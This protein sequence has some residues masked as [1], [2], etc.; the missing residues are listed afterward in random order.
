MTKYDVS[1]LIVDD[2]EEV[3]TA[4]RMLLKRHYQTI[5]TETNPERLPELMAT[6]TF[7]V[8]LLDMNFTRDA[9]S[10][11]EGFYWLE[12]IKKLDANTVVILFTA[13]GDMNIAIEAIK[14][15]AND[16]ILKPWQNEKLLAT[17]ASGVELS[18][19]KRRV[20]HLS[21]LGVLHQSEQNK[22]F[23]QLIADSPAMQQV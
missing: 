4:T 6:N 9:T 8:I 11:Q 19:S 18:V 14:N 13:F 5:V 15:G 17:V 1:I 12:K 2:N 23:E 7:S 3:L 10:G 20:E 22:L 21:Q 16:F